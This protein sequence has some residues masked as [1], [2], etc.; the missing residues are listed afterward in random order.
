MTARVLLIPCLACL[1]VGCAAETAPT[2]LGQCVR[3]AVA[4]QILDPAAGGN[5]PVAGL[6]GPA[7]QQV[8]AGYREGFA[9]EK[10]DQGGDVFSRL[11]GGAKKK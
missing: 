8:L 4:A 7:G 9:P 2:P 5:E 10:K 1:L 11:L 6:D 3:R